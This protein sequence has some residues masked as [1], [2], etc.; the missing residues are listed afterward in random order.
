M[1]ETE[2]LTDDA[3]R[4]D[5]GCDEEVGHGEVPDEEVRV[6]AQ[7]LKTRRKQRTDGTFCV[8]GQ[9]GVATAL[10]DNG[11]GGGYGCFG[12]IL[13]CCCFDF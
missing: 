2:R 5:D 6:R 9:Q 3:E 1:R 7:L 13:F 11:S 4:V 10:R 8:T 12:L